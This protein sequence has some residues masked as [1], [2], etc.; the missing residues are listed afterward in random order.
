MKDQLYFVDVIV[1]LGGVAAVVGYTPWG[2]RFYAGMALTAVSFVLWIT[3]RVQLGASFTARVEARKLV[4]MGLYSRFRDPIYFF[5]F[6]A[7]LGLAIA[8]GT[9]GGFVIVALM[10]PFQ[11][12]R[13]KK[14]RVVLERTFGEEYRAYQKRTLF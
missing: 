8:W 13:A 10:I 2:A 3:A 12:L 14:E 6:L 1:F 11:M 5:A 7:Y 4:T 9:A